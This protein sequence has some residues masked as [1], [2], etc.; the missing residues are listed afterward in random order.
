MKYKVTWK[1]GMWVVTTHF[2]SHKLVS[3]AESL[4]VA[5]MGAE[6]AWNDMYKSFMAS[7]FEGMKDV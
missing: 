3:K 6:A 4:G 2:M 1:R 7:F 5:L